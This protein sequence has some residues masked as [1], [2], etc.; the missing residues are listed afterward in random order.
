MDRNNTW[1]RV[2]KAYLAITEGIGNKSDD[3]IK[4]VEE[5]YKKKIYDE[6]FAP[7]VIIKE[8]KPIT[9]ITDGDAVI[10]YN[11]RPDRARQLTKAFVLSDFNKFTRLKYFKNLF[12]ASFTEYEKDLTTE[13]VF[14]P[15]IIKNTL[16]EVIAKAGLKQLRI[17]E[18]EKY[19]HVTY[20]FNGGRER[21]SPGEDHVLIP[22][23]RVA[24]YDLKPE[25]SSQEL[26]KKLLAAINDNKYDFILVNYPNPDMVGHTGNLAAA[27]KAVEALDSCVDKIVK[28]VL[29][30]K[31][32]VLLTADHGNAE[33]M[34]NM[35]TGQIDK[36]H[37]TNP[38][39]FIM[40]GQQFA[41]RS[42][43]WQNVV[44]SDLS[45]VQPQGILSDVAPTILKIMGLEIPEEMTGRSLIT[46]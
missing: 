16:G 30:I 42:F 9:T 7:T 22:S 28:G 4:A 29:S 33:I 25:M 43:G 15:E 19:A 44:G 12:F 37:T 23:P 2:E 11:F 39:P 38:V 8:N 18:T 35:Q 46:I 10:F 40:V 27:I 5:S 26:T 21:K 32:V 6:E 1:D 20:F 34:F 36:E 13:I 17:S 31:G 3:P 45:L 24:S 14:P 41:G